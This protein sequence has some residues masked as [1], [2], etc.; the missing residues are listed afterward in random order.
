MWGSVGICVCTYEFRCSQRP[1]DV[2]SLELGVEAVE[3]PDMGAGY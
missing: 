3:S 2:G 1:E